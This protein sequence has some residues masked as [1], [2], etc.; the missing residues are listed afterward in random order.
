MKRNLA[1]YIRDILENMQDADDFVK[2]F[3]YEAFVSDKKTFNAVVRAIE[4]IGE[5]VKNIPDD[6]RTRY[7][8]IPWREMA[9]MRDKL[10]HFYFGVD[11]EAVWLAV[12]ERMPAIRS[13]FEQV[14]RDLEK[15]KK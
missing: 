14:L 2:D 7:P 5:A 15:E 11:R 3:S 10:T 13:V 12:K 4:V 1:L 9:G 8:G 6:V